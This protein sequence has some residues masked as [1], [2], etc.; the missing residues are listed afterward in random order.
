M[1]RTRWSTGFSLRPALAALLLCTLAAQLPAADS[2]LAAF[3]S[4]ADVVIRLKSPQATIEKAAGMAAAADEKMAQQVRDNAPFIGV[5]ISNPSL[6]GVDQ[7]KDWYVVVH[8]HED[9]DPSVVFVIPATDA[10]AQQA[11]ISAKMTKFARDGWVFYGED[12]AAIE[13]LQSQTSPP[14]ASITSEIDEDS[15]AVFDAGDLSIFLNV[16]HLTEVY[17]DQLDEASGQ[18]AQ[19]LNRQAGV[20]Q[21]VPGLDLQGTIEGGTTGGADIIKDTRSLTTALSFSENGLHIETF[22]HFKE[23]SKTAEAIADH[24]GHPLKTIGQLPPGAVLYFGLSSSLSQG[25]EQGLASSAS[26]AEPTDEQQKQLKELEEKLKGVEYKSFALALGLG[27]RETGLLRIAS[28]TEAS[29]TAPVREFKQAAGDL[30][31]A[32]LEGQGIKQEADYEADAEQAGDQSIDVLTVTTTV[33]PNVNPFFGSIIKQIQGL[34]LGPEGMVSRFSY[35]DDK[36]LYTL[37]GGADAMQEAVEAVDSTESNGTTEFREGLIEEPNVVALLDVQRI[38][39]RALKAAAETPE[40][41][42]PADPAL[43]N[44][45]EPAPSYVGFSL[46]TEPHALRTKTQVPSKQLYRIVQL[47]IFARMVQQ[48][49]D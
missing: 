2:P 41:G 34:L 38:A 11:G 3:D 43:A 40:L 32:E 12:K 25:V 6:A 15:Q 8:A 5:L 22:A 20:L 42:I 17:K 1:T 47:V 35:W 46:V 4:N 45:E 10:E 39:Y 24:P 31:D 14:S 44:S 30:M 23:D 28:I 48:Q 18:F 21:M 49:R 7:E 36:Y 29:P 16:D 33:D 26:I 9:A 37:G 13:A 27:H 19:Q